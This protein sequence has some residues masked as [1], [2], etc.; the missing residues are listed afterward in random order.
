MDNDNLLK[1]DERIDQLYSQDV[2]IIQNPHCFA[3][4]LDA[5]LL[6]DFVRP[7]KKRQAKI[8]DL[9]AGN[10][11]IGLFL[12]N[13]LGGHFTEVE[14][15][16]PIA[17]MAE[18]TIKLNHLEERYDVLNMDIKDVYNKIPKDS[19]DIVLCNPPYFPNNEHS[20]KNPNR[21]LAIARH[22]ITTNLTMVVEKMSGLLKMNGRGYLVHRP[23]RLA[24][25]LNELTSHRLAPKRIRFIHPKPD[26]EA[27]IVLIE[28]IKDGGNGGIRIVPPLVVN[29]PNGEYVPEV[30]QLLYGDKK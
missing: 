24:K 15:Q 7:N 8:V 4:S 23:D 6:A 11:A 26:R 3:F 5:V 1:T 16:K 27:N 2:Q 12:H 18:R 28:V 22:E 25:I 14:L 29:Q 30:Q 10:G 19:A 20:Q 9:C 17:N 21:A 13:K